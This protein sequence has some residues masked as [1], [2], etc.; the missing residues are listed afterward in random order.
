M[1]TIS[2]TQ[3][4][5]TMIEKIT[6]AL[7]EKIDTVVPQI[8][9]ALL[10]GSIE[11]ATETIRDLTSSFEDQAWE[12]YLTNLSKCKEILVWLRQ[13]GAQKALKF[14]SYQKIMITLPSGNKI[15]VRSPYFVK[16]APKKGRKKKDPNNRGEHLLL[17]LMG[18]IHKVEPGLAFRAVQLAAIAPSFAIASQIL[19]QEGIYLSP[20]RALSG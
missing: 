12:I 13:L 15:Q 19:Q 4:K 10:S 20:N 5:N 2:I 16:A 14:V 9:N 17:S 8:E 18:F 1:E 6:Q 11:S 3:I 7:S